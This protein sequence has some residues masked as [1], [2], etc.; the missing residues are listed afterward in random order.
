MSRRKQCSTC[1]KTSW[2]EGVIDGHAF[3]RLRFV[4]FIV[5]DCGVGGGYFIDVVLLAMPVKK[6]GLNV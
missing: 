6:G 2:I 4:F 5:R 3:K 1:A